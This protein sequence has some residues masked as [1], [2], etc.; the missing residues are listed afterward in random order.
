MNMRTEIKIIAISITL[1]LTGF[2]FSCCKKTESEAIS[3]QQKLVQQIESLNQELAETEEDLKRV[4]T[5]YSKDDP[6][7]FKSEVSQLE[8]TPEAQEFLNEKLKKEEGITYEEIIEQVMLK[9]KELSSL[10][11]ERDR[12]LSMLP[13]PDVVEEGDNHYDLAMRFLIDKQ[14]LSPEDA[15]KLVERVALFDHLLPGFI[16]YHFY[17]GT[18]YGSSVLQGTA[19][20]SPNFIKERFVNKLIKERNEAIDMQKELTAELQELEIR[21]NMLTS[22]IASLETERKEIL[23]TLDQITLVSQEKDIMLSSLY[24]YAGPVS[25]LKEDGI[26][27]VSI[28]GKPSLKNVDIIEKYQTI[29]LDMAGKII[30]E[31]GELGMEKVQRINILPDLFEQGKDFSINLA[32]DGSVFEISILNKKRLKLEKIIIAVQ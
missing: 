14:G 19:S 15:R 2:I 22:Q 16:V 9:D 8:L 17:D 32:P 23:E 29:D 18:E 13:Q 25:K 5:R 31:A 27:S 28:F 3:E 1:I 20:Q 26:I 11:R 12:L 10:K 4:I 6:E 7:L 30:I 24:Y 21:K